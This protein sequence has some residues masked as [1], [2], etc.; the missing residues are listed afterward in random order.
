MFEVLKTGFIG[1]VCYKALKCFGK[2]DYADVIGLLVWVYLGFI[3][4]SKLTIWYSA[5]MNSELVKLLE[6]IF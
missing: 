6:R 1:Y 2:Q 4:C 5:L 3:I